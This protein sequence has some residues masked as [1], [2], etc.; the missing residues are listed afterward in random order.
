[1]LQS[2]Q[3]GCPGVEE[4][5]VERPWVKTYRRSEKKGRGWHG[6]GNVHQ[7]RGIAG[8]LRHVARDD[9][10]VGQHGK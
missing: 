2:W 3:G 4:R 5:S 10:R 1:V 6:V 7:R 9:W 8:A